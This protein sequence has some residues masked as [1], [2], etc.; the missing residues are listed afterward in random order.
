LKKTNRFN[1][2]SA[3]YK[4]ANE[5]STDKFY[6]I[7][8]EGTKTEPA[9]FE[10]LKKRIRLTA[11]IEVVASESSDPLNLVKYTEALVKRQKKLARKSVTAV[12][13]DEVWV[14]FDTEA[15]HSGRDWRNAVNA[16]DSKKF[17]VALSN[18]SF[19]LWFLL[20]HC[21]TTK[22]LIDCDAVIKEIKDATGSYNKSKV[23]NESY[24]NQTATA[25]ENALKL[26]KYNEQSGADNP[27]TNVDLLVTELNNAT[28]HHFR[29]F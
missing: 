28:R 17:K 23:D 2:S 6:L 20:H 19:D 11:D 5:R 8:T 26:R 10:A 27:M 4:R 22:Q 1:R 7:V 9:Y 15:P 14:V 18:P 29:L 24:L 21:Y 3:S 13:Y 16:A 12:E 25:V